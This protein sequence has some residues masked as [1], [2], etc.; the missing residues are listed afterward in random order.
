[1]GHLL[2]NLAPRTNRAAAQKLRRDCG[3]LQ[4]RL[5]AV[6][7][8]L[9]QGASRSFSFFFFS[10]FLSFLFSLPFSSLFFFSPLFFSPNF[11]PELPEVTRSPFRIRYHPSFVCQPSSIDPSS[12]ERSS[13]REKIYLQT[14]YRNS[15]GTEKY[16]RTRFRYIVVALLLLLHSIQFP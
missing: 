4:P 14:G 15:K 2:S 10:F 11:L 16:R 12:I 1:M 13:L 8:L 3:S 7:R 9:A 5:T 6:E